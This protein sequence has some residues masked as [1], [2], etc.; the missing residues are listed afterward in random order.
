MNY[1]MNRLAGTGEVLTRSPLPPH[2]DDKRGVVFM[3][4]QHGDLV[5]TVLET[6][7]VLVFMGVS[8]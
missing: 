4:N 6:H 5:S 7:A 2:N 3:W 8:V 1:Y